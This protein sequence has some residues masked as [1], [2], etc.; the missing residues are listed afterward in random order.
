MLRV[1]I[2]TLL[3]ISVFHVHGQQIKVRAVDSSRLVSLPS[4]SGRIIKALSFKDTVGEHTIVLRETGI[5]GSKGDEDLRSAELTAQSFL[6]GV[7]EWRIYDAVKDCPVDVNCKF[8]ADRCWVTDLDKNGHAEVWVMY[9]LGCAGDV[10]PRI[11]KLIMYENKTKYAMRGESRVTLSP[12][13][14]AGGGYQ[15]DERFAKGPEA[16]KKFASTIWKKH[17]NL[18]WEEL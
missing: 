13:Y 14:S 17:M 16:F 18:K 12:N 10:S 3:S 15:F 11:L 2:I 5:Y 4:G 9:I 7:Q 8:W 1:F 6:G